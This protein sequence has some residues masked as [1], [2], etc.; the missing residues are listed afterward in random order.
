M[1]DETK[2]KRDEGRLPV[3]TYHAGSRTFDRLFKEKTL[4]E[5][6][7]VVR[8]KLGLDTNTVVQLKQV[9][10]DKL[11]D[12]EDDDDFDAFRSCTRFPSLS[13]EVQ[14]TVGGTAPPGP[15]SE[16]PP[17]APRLSDVAASIADIVDDM[18]T[19]T[20]SKSVE[21]PKKV[22]V[23]VQEPE[24]DSG[25]SAKPTKKRRKSTS[26]KEKE[27]EKEKE[28]QAGP[29]VLVRTAPESPKAGA[30]KAA[31]PIATE[32]T[33]SIPKPVEEPPKKKRKITKGKEGPPDQGG[34]DS[35]NRKNAKAS[36]SDKKKDQKVAESA[37]V[38]TAEPSPE[39]PKK[40]KKR[41]EETVAPSEPAVSSAGADL[42]P[43]MLCL[44][45]SSQY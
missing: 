23:S 13:A 6:K 40:K 8:R 30:K 36:K 35:E 17:A 32:G 25:E 28:K 45:F 27:R 26:E 44:H 34:E 2:R 9:R 16:I 39:K 7:D 12:L 41:T 10:M 11:V 4:E 1:S 24:K 38:E 42:V 19:A 29:S 21:A 20:A 37:E 31:S 33:T 22:K 18:R 43:G 3:V 15:I 14:V 5:M